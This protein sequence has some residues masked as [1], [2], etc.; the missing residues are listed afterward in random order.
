MYFGIL[1]AEYVDSLYLAVLYYD[2]RARQ[3]PLVEM[4]RQCTT[5]LGVSWKT[6][7]NY[8]K[9]QICVVDPR[10]EL[11]NASDSQPVD[12]VPCKP[13]LNVRLHQKSPIQRIFL[14]SDMEYTVPNTRIKQR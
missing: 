8:A 12:W 4:A 6:A 13:T 11:L 1:Q 9:L 2:V 10:C 7:Y 5:I 3:L 14:K